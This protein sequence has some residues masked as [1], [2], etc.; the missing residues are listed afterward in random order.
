MNK[1]KII[2]SILALLISAFAFAQSNKEI[3]GEKLYKAYSYSKAINK[4]EGI[5]EK[6]TKVKRELADSYFKVGDYAKSEEYYAQLSLSSDKQPDDVYNYAYVLLMNKKYKEA[7]KWMGIYNKLKPIDSRA[8]M[9]IN[10][11]MYYNNLLKDKGQFSIKNLDINTSAQEFGT[12]YYN[13]HIVFASTRTGV[14][15]IVRKWNWNR[16]SFLNLFHSTADENNE[17]SDI[18]K[19]RRKINRKY[20]DGPASFSA[21]G[22]YMVF[23]RNNYENTDTDG[24]VRLELLSSEYVDGEW[25]NE[26]LLPFNNDNYSVGHGSLSSDSKTLYFASDMPGGKGGVDIYKAIRNTDGSWGKAINLGDKINTEGNEMFPF[27]QTEGELLFFASD[28]HPGLGGLDNFVTFVSEG[29]YGDP[30]NMG[31]PINTNMDDFAFVLDD[32]QKA[33]YLSS[34]REGGKGDDDIYS[35]KLLKPFN[36]GKLI[37]GTATDKQNNIL[38]N[39]EVVLYNNSG[40]EIGRVTTTDNGKYS[41]EVEADKK[42]KLLGEKADYFNGNNTADTH[43]DDYIVIADL[44]LEKDPKMAL[45]CLVTDK[46]SKQPIDDVKIVLVNNLT[47]SEEVINTPVSGDFLRNL[48]NKRLNDKIDYTLNLSKTGYVAKSVDYKKILKKPGQYNI[49]E[50]MD[51]SLEPFVVGMDLTEAIKINPIY[52]DLDKYNIR[53]DAALELDKIVEIMNEY[54]N[55]VI[56]LGSHTDCRASVEYNRVLSANRA[57][58]SAKYIKSR[59]PNPANIYGKGYGESQLVNECECEGKKVVPC[60]EEQ[61]Q[62]NRRTEFVIIKM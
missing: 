48:L 59:I 3:K 24:V 31:T 47:K 14:E 5:T 19:C 15:S 49:H 61:H 30:I 29:S 12:S 38:A 57:K 18:T 60:T 23:T 10:N 46:K 22:S 16:K 33:G 34:N 50:E 55:M 25:V 7:V 37:K 52:F 40:K 27:I 36:F 21:D 41:F 45:Y 43:T 2:I 35:F 28:G 13:N 20:H 8:T 54:P 56:E 39:T 32:K 1:S 44:V 9:V 42:F 6:S 62:Q 17:L 51:M 4:L 53:P 26:N 58:A 11:K